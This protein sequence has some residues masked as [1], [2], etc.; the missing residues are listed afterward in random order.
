MSYVAKQLLISNVLGRRDRNAIIFCDLKFDLTKTVVIDDLI[1]HL[2]MAKHGEV[3]LGS[4]KRCA[5]CGAAERPVKRDGR[6]LTADFSSTHSNACFDWNWS[7]KL[8]FCNC[9]MKFFGP[10]NPFLLP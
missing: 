6:A 3:Q 10:G 5:V 2:G 9:A 1:N 8:S 4:Q 7:G